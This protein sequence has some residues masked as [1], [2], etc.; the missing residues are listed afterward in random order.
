MGKGE[1]NGSIAS[2]KNKYA[3]LAEESLGKSGPYIVDAVIAVQNGGAVCSYV[4]ILGGLAT[5]LLS[6][7][8]EWLQV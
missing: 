6:E 1:S 7:L 3:M 8:L 2:P 5:S 4:V